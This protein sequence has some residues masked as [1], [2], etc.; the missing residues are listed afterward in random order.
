MHEHI[1]QKEDLVVEETVLELPGRR[2]AGL[3]SVGVQTRINSRAAGVDLVLTISL[4]S[5]HGYV[6]PF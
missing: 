3:F 2:F 1:V 6:A 4:H 5:K